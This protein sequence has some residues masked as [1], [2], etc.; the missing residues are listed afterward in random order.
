MIRC[1]SWF[2]SSTNWEGIL[3][4]KHLMDLVLVQSLIQLVVARIQNYLL[5]SCGDVFIKNKQTT[6]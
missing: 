6:F 5:Q 1:F 2:F 3:P 4:P